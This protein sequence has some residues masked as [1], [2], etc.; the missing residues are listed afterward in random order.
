MKSCRP[1]PTCQGLSPPF[2]MLTTL[3]Q[4]EEA[5][6]RLSDLFSGFIDPDEG[7]PALPR[8]MCLNLKVATDLSDDEDG[9]SD[10][11]EDDEDSNASEG[12]PLT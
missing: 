12:G 3:T 11:E 1:W 8:R 5:P 6:G 7:I 9:D 10:G 2:W 4:D